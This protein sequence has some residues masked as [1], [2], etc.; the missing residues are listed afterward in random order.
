MNSD[1]KVSGNPVAGGEQDDIARNQPFGVD[2]KRLFALPQ[3]VAFSLD[4]LGQGVDRALRLLLLDEPDD[5]VN[6]RHR[7]NDGGVGWAPGQK[8]RG[9]GNEQ[10]DDERILELGEKP[11]PGRGSRRRAEDVLSLGREALFGLLGGQPD[12]GIGFETFTGFL[13]GK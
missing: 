13:P 4:H 3:N 9:G 2:A 6:D 5:G 8:T 10:D 1:P 7:D 11:A 12:L